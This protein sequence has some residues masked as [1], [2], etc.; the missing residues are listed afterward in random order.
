MQDSLKPGWADYLFKP[1]HALSA[2]QL[3]LGNAAEWENPTN[4]SVFAPAQKAGMSP[5]VFCVAD[6]FEDHREQLCDSF[7]T[8]LWISPTDAWVSSRMKPS[9]CSIPLMLAN[10]RARLFE[11]IDATP[12]LNWALLT[13]HP[14][15][16][17]AMMPQ[18]GDTCHCGLGE[19]DHRYGGAAEHNYTPAN[20]FRPNVWLGTIVTDQ[21]TADIRIPHLLRVPAAV[22]FLSCAQL[23]GPVDL[24]KY[25]GDA[26]ECPEC[27]DDDESGKY[28][29][30]PRHKYCGVCAEDNGRDVL[31][32]RKGKLLHWVTASGESGPHARPSHPAW[33]RGLRDQCVAARVPFWFDGW[34]DLVHEHECEHSQDGQLLSF[35]GPDWY[36]RVGRDKSGRMLDGREW[37]QLPDVGQHK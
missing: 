29:M 18:Y 28:L 19:S 7:G 13:N 31:L 4:W 25:L 22:R 34:G 1:W 5:R 33:F 20:I 32:S 26:W 37:L 2:T 15:N 3:A 17:A 9:S 8:K 21:A 24:T 6:V 27:G 16:I 11:M 36:R 12:N 23:L 30:T 10:V 35:G 14:E